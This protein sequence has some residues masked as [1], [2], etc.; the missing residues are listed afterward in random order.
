MKLFEIITAFWG[1]DLEEEAIL[2]YV[3]G[4]T[5]DAAYDYINDKHRYGDW[6]EQVAMTREELIAAEGDFQTE[7][8]GEFYD[9]KYG[10]K[11]LG[12]IAPEDIACFQ[13]F[14]ILPDL[15]LEQQK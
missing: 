5:A 10:W 13:Y 12:V 8:M 14:K 1:K 15:D 9:Q 2:G 11:D 3:V 4:E 7:Y 6:P